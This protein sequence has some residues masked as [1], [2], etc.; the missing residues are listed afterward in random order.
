MSHVKDSY[1]FRLII[2]PA[3]ILE[4]GFVLDRAALEACRRQQQRLVDEGIWSVS[5]PVLFDLN[6]RLHEV[7]IERSRNSFFIDGLR[8]VDRLRRLMEYKQSL[9][10][11][12]A[13]VRCR[14]HIEL[15]DLLLDDRRE[16]ASEFMN[17]HLSSVSVEKVM[18]G[19]TQAVSSADD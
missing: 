12:Y 15:I 3:A 6:S 14:E 18:N 9:D 5:S 8:R 19:P 2:E 10:R 7:I 17:R 11:R 1:R 4:P 13:I 16:D